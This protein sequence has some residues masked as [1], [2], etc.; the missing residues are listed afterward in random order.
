M[1][2]AEMLTTA[3]CSLLNISFFLVGGIPVAR[4]N[5]FLRTIA[6]KERKGGGG[7]SSHWHNCDPN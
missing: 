5:L 3:K 2:H 1:P 4:S 7:V 6:V